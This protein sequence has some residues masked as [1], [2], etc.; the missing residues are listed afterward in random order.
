MS[1][2]RRP[3]KTVRAFKPTPAAAA[4][5]A[6]VVG[7]PPVAPAAPEGGAEAASAPQKASSPAR[8]TS[9]TPP[10]GEEAAKEEGAAA[11]AT[12]EADGQSAPNDEHVDPVSKMNSML[13]AASI[14]AGGDEDEDDE[15]AE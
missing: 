9:T 11:T 6:S 12:A 3:R 7:T 1:Q 15:W 14:D 8:T 2:R 13:K 10:P 5:A 4:A